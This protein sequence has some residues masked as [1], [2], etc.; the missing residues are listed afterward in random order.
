MEFLTKAQIK[1]VKSLHQKKTRDT[2]KCFV[3]EGEKMVKEGLE[4]FSDQLLHLYALNAYFEEIP[5]EF[6]H[7]TVMVN[8]KELHQL[9]E[10]KTPNKF[11]AV[12]RKPKATNANKGF[13]I[14]LDGVQDPG[15]MGTILRLA[16]WYDIKTIIC[17]SDTVDVYNSKVVQASMGAIY[18][19]D[20]QY[21]N[22]ISFL[23]N[24]DQPIYGALLNGEDYR[25]V[26]YAKNGLLVM[27][28]EG[29]GIRTEIQNLIQ[30][31]VTIPRFG[32]AESLNVATATAILLSEIIK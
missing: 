20:V 18:R 11:I 12:F 15:N 23:E 6:R 1:W 24:T 25:E 27:G 26:S 30:T 2:E 9:S 21:T 16:D 29:A 17:S 14:V 7:L 13:S 4:Y 31:K 8:E 10:L 32:K 22:L 5:V 19:I 28:N 3:V